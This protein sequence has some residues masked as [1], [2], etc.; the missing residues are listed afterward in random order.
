MSL[1]KAIQKKHF[2]IG[3]KDDVSNMSI[4]YDRNFIIKEENQVNCLFY[5]LGSDGTVGANKNS[6]KIIGEET[7]L[8]AQ[9]YFVYDSK[10]SG[11]RTVSHLRFGPKPIDSPYLIQSADFI[12]VHQFNFVDKTDVLAH[13]APNGT[14]LLNSTYGPDEVWQHLPRNVQEVIINKKLTFY[15]VDAY[16]VAQET[17]M[18]Q[19]TNTIMQTC[20]FAL[21][22][23]LPEKEAIDKIKEYI[24]KTYIKKGEEIVQKNFNAVDKS[25]ANLHRVNV[26]SSVSS[27]AHEMPPAVSE[28]APEFV[29]NVIAKMM[30]DCGDELAVSELP[31]DGT[32]PCGTTK[33]EKRNVSFDA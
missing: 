18:G 9:G 25:L 11:S 32:Y 27:N 16:K 24:K 29:R 26:P 2:T 19:R 14:F 22:K 17:G 1:E 4:D 10:K 23:V 5:G 21:S 20:F 13:A 6:I 31:N 30:K 15:V 8:Y 28:K 3:I 33:W 12:G 7:D